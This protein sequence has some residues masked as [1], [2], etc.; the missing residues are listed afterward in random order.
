MRFISVYCAQYLDTSLHP[1][2]P[3]VVDYECAEVLNAEQLNAP[4]ILLD[5]GENEGLI[6]LREDEQEPHYVVGDG[7]HRLLAANRMSAT[8]SAYVLSAEESASYGTALE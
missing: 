8:V 5:F 4:I 1:R 2:P 6:S 3:I 7:N